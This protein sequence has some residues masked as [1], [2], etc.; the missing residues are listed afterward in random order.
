MS[1][2]AQGRTL[3]RV[4][5]AA[6]Y[7]MIPLLFGPLMLLGGMLMTLGAPRSRTT[8][9]VVLLV[10]LGITAMGIRGT[11]RRT[12]LI[13][14][15][16][17]G[18][19]IYANADGICVSYSMCRDL[20]IPW[21]RLES[22]RFLTPKQI[23]TERLWVAAGSP[24]GTPGCV[25][26][27]LR[28]DWSWPPPGTLRDGIATRRAK[29]GEIYLDSMQCSPSGIKLWAQLAPLVAKYGGPDVA[30][31]MTSRADKQGWQSKVS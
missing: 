4:I 11:R 22:M 29:P 28:M 18:I 2:P 25:A 12:V 19:M 24:I 14:V 20:F 6:F 26:L 9:I 1:E 5:P 17:H 3:L 30:M 10:G 21:E 13:E 16:E 15:T 23:S 31:D 7:L 8:G 27:K